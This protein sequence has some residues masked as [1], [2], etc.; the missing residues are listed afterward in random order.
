MSRYS[1]IR[2]STKRMMNEDESGDYVGVPALLV[3]M[4]SAGWIKPAVRRRKIKLY[5]LRDLDRCCDR[6]AAGEWPEETA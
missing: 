3:R 4:E 5:D 2:V 1:V 6:L